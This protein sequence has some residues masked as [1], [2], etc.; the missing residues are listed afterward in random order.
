[1]KN[2]LYILAFF[3]FTACQAT[4]NQP[5]QSSTPEK[6]VFG[7]MAFSDSDDNRARMDSLSAYLSRKMEMPVEHQL[8]ENYSQLIK[9]MKENRVH[10]SENG[11]FSYILA[12]EEANAE[13][14][15]SFA[16]PDGSL[17][18]Y[19]SCLISRSD[20]KL[21]NI[22]DLKAN[23]SQIRM[24][25]VDPISTSGYLIPRSQFIQMGMHPS[26]DFAHVQF[27]G[28]HSK[29]IKNLIDNKI[30]VA[31][32]WDFALT[33]LIRQG[34]IKKSDIRVLW[35]SEAVPSESIYVRKDLPAAVKR[36]LQQAYLDMHRDDPQLYA[37]ISRDW[38]KKIAF[39]AIDDKV[40]EGLRLLAKTM[41]SDEE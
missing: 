34:E 4:E 19:K 13:A 15:V 18:T 38:G 36:K 10:I 40:Y 27:T 31:A 33:E 22:N 5:I 11:T 26:K 8:F 21:Q 1:M 23:A 30:D 37:L 29:S 17:Q 9:A 2:L 24:G 25:F 14:L 41:D 35:A 6:L 16:N 32:I 3:L 39:V 20:S 7:I 28:S 12:A